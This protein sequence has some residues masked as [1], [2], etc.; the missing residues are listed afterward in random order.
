MYYNFSND[1]TEC[2]SLDMYVNRDAH[3]LQVRHISGAWDGSPTPTP[4]QLIKTYTY[5]RFDTFL[6]RG[7]VA[8]RLHQ[9]RR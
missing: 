5:C 7:T 8:L 4:E 2:G 9:T 6:V 3:I 1:K